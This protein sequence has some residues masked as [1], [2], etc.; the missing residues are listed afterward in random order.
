MT[1]PPHYSLSHGDL[2][3][4]HC[5]MQ[6]AS[7]AL[8]FSVLPSLIGWSPSSRKGHQLSKQQPLRLEQRGQS[9]RSMHH[10]MVNLNPI[11]P[12]GGAA[13]G[14]RELQWRGW[15]GLGN[16]SQPLDRTWVP[17]MLQAAVNS[18]HYYFL[19]TRRS[20]QHPIILFS[21][22]PPNSSAFFHLLGLHACLSE[23]ST[24]AIR[25]E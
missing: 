25:P 14:P 5:A 11:N 7:D 23:V 12:Q 1:L 8:T 20:H 15:R 16:S 13:H 4:P 22:A 2:S 10:P 21:P 17:L 24:K 6:M 9:P 19:Q 3:E 18:R